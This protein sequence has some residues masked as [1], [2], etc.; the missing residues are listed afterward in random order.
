MAKQKMAPRGKAAGPK[1]KTMAD[2]PKLPS[3]PPKP[4][5]LKSLGP[6]GGGT[7]EANPPIVPRNSQPGVKQ[8]VGIKNPMSA[9]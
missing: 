7:G 3:R 6:V 5:I 8:R 4:R 9:I 2:I 1:L